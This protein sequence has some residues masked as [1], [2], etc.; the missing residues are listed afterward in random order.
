[1]GPGP[2]MQFPALLAL[3]RVA[4]VA[5]EQP[6]VPPSG[7]QSPTAPLASDPAPQ[8]VLILGSKASLCL[9]QSLL[10]PAP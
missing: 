4:C 2:P 1:M 5:L 3:L 6:R 7:R 8:W 9:P 10:C